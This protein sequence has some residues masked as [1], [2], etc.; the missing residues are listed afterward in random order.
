MKPALEKP[1]EATR[2]NV[3]DFRKND[4]AYKVIPTER[5]ESFHIVGLKIEALE[6]LLKL[7]KIEMNKNTI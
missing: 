2:R 4:E 6:E 5:Q 3:D 7:L 1:K